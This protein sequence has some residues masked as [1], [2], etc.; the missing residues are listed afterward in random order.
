MAPKNSNASKSVETVVTNIETKTPAEFLAEFKE[1]Q[2]K[3]NSMKSGLT[4]QVEAIDREI[5]ELTA[6]IQPTMNR[7]G[8]LRIQRKTLT[9]NDGDNSATRT[10]EVTACPDCGQGR[11]AKNE[12]TDKCSI[13]PGFSAAVNSAKE[14]KEAIPTFAQYLKSIGRAA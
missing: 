8:E 10:R 4:L 3:L 12:K 13:Y 14:K 11:H 1:L 2:E 6:Q 9:G 7:I 5:Q